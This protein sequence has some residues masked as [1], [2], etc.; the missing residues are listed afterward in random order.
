MKNNK[1]VKWFL[2]NGVAISSCTL[3]A[4]FGIGYIV[5]SNPGPSTIGEDVTVGNNLIVNGNATALGNVKGAQV[6]IGSVCKASWDTFQNRVVGSCPSGSAIQTINTDGTVV[7][8]SCGGGS[9]P[10]YFCIPRSGAISCITACG[11]A[12]GLCVAE[13]NGGLDCSGATVACSGYAGQY[14]K[15]SSESACVPRSGASSCVL[16]CGNIGRSCVA[17]YNGGV[18]CSGTIVAC[19][20]SAGQ[21]CMCQ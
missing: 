12:N 10:S 15:C 7:C 11:S 8:Q 17:Q 16:V 20:G 9:T 14:C 1:I 21:Y 6:C 4:V 5:W 3:V 2:R 19:S 18:D 13:Y